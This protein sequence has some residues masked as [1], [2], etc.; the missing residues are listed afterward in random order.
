MTRL[1]SFGYRAVDMDIGEMFLNFPLHKTLRDLSG[2]DLTPFQD[3][4]VN[5]PAR[6]LYANRFFIPNQRLTT[7]WTRVWFG[8]RQ[9]PEVAFMYYYFAEEFIRGNHLEVNNPLRW[10]EIRLNL[11]GSTNYN[12]TFPNVY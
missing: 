12:P 1:L 10:D 6:Y 7:T 9:S 5:S 8:S 11:I 2:V 4:L 3:H